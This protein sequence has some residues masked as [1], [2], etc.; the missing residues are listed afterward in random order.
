MVISD[1]NP[2]ITYGKMLDPA[3]LPKRLRQK[4]GNTMPSLSVFWVF[5]GL[6]RDLYAHGMSA[7][8]IWDYPS[9]N[10]EAGFKS[11]FEGRIC[12]DGM[13]FIS[14]NS[15]KDDSH[16]LAPLGKS[17]LEAITVMPYEPFA[18]WEGLSAAERGPEY[19]Q[20]KLGIGNA[21]VAE[22]DKRLPGVLSDVEVVEFATPID[23]NFRTKALR[24]GIYGPAVSP[25]LT[26]PRRF[27]TRSPIRNLY[28]VGAGVFGGSIGGAVASGSMQQE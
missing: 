22:L 26:P 6:N 21:L 12:T 2:V 3:E 16:S 9:W 8:N 5:L 19:E 14:P 4:V 1:V 17:T 27:T 20:L 15:L 28:L 11:A 24:G 13:L 18:K 7:Y 25:E 23:M 10:I